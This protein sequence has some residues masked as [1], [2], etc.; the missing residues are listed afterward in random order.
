[1]EFKFCYYGLYFEYSLT[2][3]LTCEYRNMIFF[4]CFA[5]YVAAPGVSVTGYFSGEHYADVCYPI[6]GES[7]NGF[8]G[9]NTAPVVVQ[10]KWDFLGLENLG[11]GFIQDDNGWNAGVYTDANKTRDVIEMHVKWLVA[12]YS[13]SSLYTTA[14]NR[15]RRA[16]IDV[17]E[18]QNSTI[19][20]IVDN[21]WIQPIGSP[22]VSVALFNLNAWS[23]VK[24]TGPMTT[25]FQV[26]TSQNTPFFKFPGHYLG[27]QC[28][29]EE[30]GVASGR[31]F[32]AQASGNYPT[33]SV[34]D[35]FEISAN[36]GN[37]CPGGTDA[38]TNRPIVGPCMQGGITLGAGGYAIPIATSGYSIQANI[39]SQAPAMGL[40]YQ[41][42][43]GIG[44]QLIITP[45]TSTA[46]ASGTWVSS[47][48]GATTNASGTWAVSGT[49]GITSWTITNH[50]DRMTSAPTINLT[51][52]SGSIPSGGA[53]T[54]IW[55]SALATSGASASFGNTLGTSVFY[56]G[57]APNN[58]VN[59]YLQGL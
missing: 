40:I 13:D 29:W 51:A 31:F 5:A 11:M 33:T 34:G 49:T 42:A 56:S 41:K 46:A 48:G 3:I 39:G 4:N 18:M 16:F 23:G 7:G 32:S 9:S 25:I 47:G 28:I 14:A 17:N 52:T 12:S 55:P 26:A 6:L 43:T 1:M 36:F 37:I 54:P 2:N 21:G 30:P 15:T 10:A 53:L 22:P 19:E 35:V 45:G 27:S 59:L 44:A 24:L 57:S 50:G 58:H 8:A 20:N 38:T